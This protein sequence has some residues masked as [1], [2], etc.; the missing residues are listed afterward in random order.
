MFHALNLTLMCIHHHAHLYALKPQPCTIQRTFAS[1]DPGDPCRWNV[2][3]VSAGIMDW[4]TGGQFGDH[5][6]GQRCH[7]LTAG[8]PPLQIVTPLIHMSMEGE[9][10]RRVSHQS[11]VTPVTLFLKGWLDP[12]PPLFHPSNIRCRETFPYRNH[13]QTCCYSHFFAKKC[14]LLAFLCQETL[15]ASGVGDHISSSRNCETDNGYNACMHATAHTPL[16]GR[17]LGD[18]QRVLQPKKGR[19]LVHV[20]TSHSD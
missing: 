8:P 15:S 1:R 17:P 2:F 19:R 12:P 14:Y 9:V 7:S 6:S 16:L 13:A 4:S 3:C 11:A 5:G 10:S 20:H 18:R